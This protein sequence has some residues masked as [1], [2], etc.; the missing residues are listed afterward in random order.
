MTLYYEVAFQI[1]VCSMVLNLPS[2]PD[3]AMGRR[4]RFRSVPG[5]GCGVGI[6]PEVFNSLRDEV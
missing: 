3:S 1:Y 6:G 5:D 2:G 4:D